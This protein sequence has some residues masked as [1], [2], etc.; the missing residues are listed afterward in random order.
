MKIS[1]NWL[2]DYLDF[3]ES[4]ALLGEI[5]TEIGLEVEGMEKT[6]SI[7]GGLQGVI[8]GEVRTV[9]PHPNADRLRKTTVDVGQPELLHIVCGAPNVE[10]G[11][12][13][14]VA[15]PGTTLYPTE[16]EPF[17]IRKSKIRG[18]VSEGMICAEDELGLGTSHEGI[19]VLDEKTGT[20]ISASELFEVVTDFVFDIGLT[21]NRSDATSHLGVA[22][23]LAAALTFK[24]GRHHQVKTPDVSAFHADT[25]RHDVGVTVDNGELCPRYSSLTISELTLGPSPRWMTDRLKAVGVRPIN[26]VVD[27]TNFI[28]HETGQPLHAFDLQ[29]LKGNQVYVRC[30]E[31]GTTFRTLD[32]VDRTLTGEDL[33]ICNAESEPM[34]IAGVFGGANS[35][36]T[37]TTSDIFLESAHFDSTSVRK[38]S[39]WHNLRTDAARVFEK[40]SDPSVTTFALKRAALLFKEYAGGE[41]SS[42]ISDIVEGEIKR[43]QVCLRLPRLEK[44][45]GVKIPEDDILTILDA[46]DMEIVERKVDSLELLVPTSKADVVREADVIEEILRIY[47]FNRIPVGTKLEISLDSGQRDL[48]LIY[49]NRISMLLSGMGLDE[50]MGLSFSLPQYLPTRESADYVRIHNTSNKELE[51]M[52]PDLIST[53]LATVEYNQKRQNNVLN[54][55]EFG[56]SYSYENDELREKEHLAISLAGSDLGGNWIMGDRPSGFYFLKSILARIVDSVNLRGYQEADLDHPAFQYGVRWYRGS[57]EIAV[58]GKLDPARYSQTDV[59]GEVYFG[60]I[61]WSNLIQMASPVLKTEPISRYPSMERDLALIVSSDVRFSDIRSEIGRVG[62]RLIREVSLFDVYDE[63]DHLGEGKRS[64]GVKILFS[65]PDKTLADKEV[66]QKV[67]KIL[68]NLQS[69]WGITLR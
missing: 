38:S 3:E 37:A 47:G 10:V 19:L 7:R 42:R 1:Y 17:E 34:C 48:Q 41:I 51:I 44:I 36:V 69:K 31:K 60:D 54:T 61:H 40:G 8:T 63:P 18:E 58:F 43:A 56:R 49:R 13:V 27:I 21:P 6:E 35:G 15:P 4:P 5:L 50:T 62:G 65:D 66:D 53:A 45:V 57:Q 16:G 30:L 2:K 12:K 24:H 14:L 46:L 11:Q 33:M 59:R 29:A 25:I 32:E 9:E 52:R 26:N 68:N 39:V 55:Y 23:D 20:G 28:L 22:R 67:S 64:Y